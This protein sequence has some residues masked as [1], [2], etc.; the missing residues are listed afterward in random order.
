ME[1]PARSYWEAQG[2]QQPGQPTGG[3]AT[4]RADATLAGRAF[5]FPGLVILRFPTSSTR[6]IAFLAANPSGGDAW[7]STSC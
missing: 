3:G 7:P 5:C 2:S 1:F 4:A 6:S